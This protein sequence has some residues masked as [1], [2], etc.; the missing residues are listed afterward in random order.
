MP[1]VSLVPDSVLL[2]IF[3]SFFFFLMIRRPP[4]STLSSSS[5]ASD[6]YKRQV[7]NSAPN[8]SVGSCYGAVGIN[9]F[10][11]INSPEGDYKVKFAGMLFSA[12]ILTIILGFLLYL[13]HNK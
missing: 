3:L 13:L 6:V 4:R 11:S 12:N 5:A 1:L 2:S 8:Q 7:Y 10:N 9:P